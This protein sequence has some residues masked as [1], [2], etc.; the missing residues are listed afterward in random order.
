MISW[1]IE[2]FSKNYFPLLQ[3]MKKFSA[4][5]IFISE[6][7]I[8]QCDLQPLLQPFLGTYSAHLNSEDVHDLELPL[9]HPR[10]KGGTLIMWHNSLS[11]NMKILD[12][13]SSSFISVLLS[14]PGLIPSLHTAVYFPTAGKD[15]DWLACLVELEHHLTEVMEEYNGNL[16][17]F[18]RGDLNASSKNK[19][20]SSFLSAFVSRLELLKVIIPH[21]SYHHFVGGGEFDSDL[22]VLLYG[23]CEGVHEYL[24]EIVCELRHPLM[25]S[26]HD[27]IISK[28]NIPTQQCQPHDSQHN[29]IAPRVQ[30]NRFRTKWTE[31]GMAEYKE[32]LNT[33]LPEIRQTWGSTGS[34]SNM[35]LLLSSTYSAMNI[36]SKGTNKCIMTA[37]TLKPKHKVSPSV[38][39]AANKSLK[40]LQNLRK[41]EQTL[42]VT[43]QQMEAAKDRLEN[44][45]K[46]FKKEVRHDLAVARDKVDTDLHNILSDPST[47]FRSLRSA[48]KSS[49]PPV[50]KLHVGDKVY[51]GDAV[52]DGMYDSL[53]SLKAPCMDQHNSNPSYLEAVQTY[54]HIIK[55]ATKG[56]KIPSISLAQGEKILRGLKPTV[57]DWYSVTSLHYLH[58]GHEGILHFVFLMNSIIGNINC[59]TLEE[60]NTIWAIILHKGGGKDKELD[61]SWRTISCCPL[62][63]KAL[64]T[65]MVQLYNAGWSAAQAPTQFQGDNS[66]HDL[67]SLCVTEA[68]IHGLYTNKEP[69]YLLLLDAQ[70]AYDRVVIEHAVRCAYLAGTQDEGLLYLDHRLR[71]RRTMVEWEK[72]ILG[73]IKDTQGVEQGGCPSDKVYRLV[74]NEQLVTAQ[75]SG[76]G[77]DLGSVASPE[78]LIR[79][80]L[81]S[82]GLADDVGLLAGSLAKLRALLHLTKLYCDKYQ[83]K[84]VASK[85]KLIV[86]SDKHTVMQSRVELATTT[87]K[88]DGQ[89]IS[90]SKE[91]THVGVVR[92]AEGNG[93]NISARLS[94]HR[95][96]VFA[97]LYAGL[98]KGHR[99]NPTAC[100]RVE[101]V[102]ALPVLLSG[103]A[104]IVL[105][106]KEEK[107]IGQHHKV[108][109]QRLLR[110]HQSTPAPVVFFLAGCLPFQ[111]QLH[112]RMF[113][114]FGQLCR[115][116]SGDNILAKH[117][118]NVL[119][120]GNSS[121]KSWFWKLRAVCLQYGLPHPLVWLSSQ[122]TKL[123]LKRLV[124]SAVTQ[125]WLAQMRT[126][127][128]SLTSLRYLKTEYLG[129]SKCHSIFT[130][131]G[132][133]PWEVEKAT[134]QAR[135]LSGRY[136]VEALSG[137]WVPWNR[138]GLC[139]LPTCW[140][141]EESHKGTVESLLLSCPSLSTTRANLMQFCW[142]FLHKFPLLI[143]LVRACLALDPAQFWLDC[144]TMAPVISAVQ[145]EGECVL[146]PLFKVTRNYCHVLHTARVKMLS[147][148]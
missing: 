9:T 41:L 23:G 89:I 47:A 20:R 107:I 110:L 117:A 112:L 11:P 72:E 84:L 142:S 119:A 83:V 100:L 70:S 4:M 104:S 62:L 60:L 48:R 28:C 59:S 137:H 16:A 29:I 125:Y 101:T 131:C 17:V 106:S 6:P 65:Y 111:A 81:G 43:E 52:A 99:A 73:P 75:Q 2:G 36:I 10:A 74:N 88:V 35:S 108:H 14:P 77:V 66:S 25:F 40:E 92:C 114:V 139:S 91:A 144:S 140:G 129:L 136:R 86:Y 147:N 12:T 63:A 5:L 71:S 19:T 95:K 45:R 135:L 57:M 148:D 33:I 7:Q 49:A 98:A 44:S 105:T 76:L 1:N 3:L 113:S 13:N 93:P 97:L 116:R 118:L 124:K 51:C 120:S 53:D 133:S 130:T 85:T 138:G 8:Y 56:G 39:V 34:I 79:L 121:S 18:I 68:V 54:H 123:E 96:A 55:L 109:L 146:F 22:D 50:K 37:D 82:V 69:V 127:A 141:S 26:H 102:F 90:P 21:M 42:N 27:L 132:S 58:L 31:E 67:A 122:P 30:N 134:T 87:I 64:D 24:V 128:S 15:G 38:R 145:D 32:Q 115:L 126:K 78:G 61:R 46:Q 80:V 103:L 143:S 94:A